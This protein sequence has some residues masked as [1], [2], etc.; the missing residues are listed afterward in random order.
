MEWAFAPALEVC[1]DAGIVLVLVVFM[2]A[3]HED[4]RNR[5]I[6]LSGTRNVTS[7]TKALG[8]AARR[9]RRYLLRPVLRQLLLRP[10]R[11]GSGCG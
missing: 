11:R 5:I 2:L 6:R 7:T 9:V 3:Q 1:V 4:L 8:E 10:G